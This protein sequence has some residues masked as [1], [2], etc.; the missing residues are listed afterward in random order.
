MTV[1]FKHSS[2]PEFKVIVTG[3]V[4]IP[5]PLTIAVISVPAGEPS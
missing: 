3:V 4:L 2:E 5:T 1:G